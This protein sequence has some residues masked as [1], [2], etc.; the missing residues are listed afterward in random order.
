MS[1]EPRL[2]ADL[3]R[4][5]FEVAAQGDARTVLQIILVAQRCRAWIEPMLYRSV[6]VCQSSWSLPLFLRTIEARPAHYA[7][8]IKAIQIDPY[9][10][11]NDPAVTRIL[12]ICTRV[13]EL[14]DLSY[15]LTPF[16]VLA[17]LRL[18][19]MCMSLDVVDGLAEGAYFKHAA[20]AHLT[21]L[22]VLDPPQ[23]WPHI[24]FAHLPSLTHLALQN[25]KIEIRPANVPILQRILSTCPLLEV[26]VVCIPLCRPEDQNA[27]ATK[28]LVDD[29]RLV[30]LSQ[31]LHSSHNLWSRPFADTCAAVNCTEQETDSIDFGACERHLDNVLANKVGELGF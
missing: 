13:V 4:T 18:E 11:L 3:E 31:T 10:T 6:V 1:A 16:S 23:R 5:I 26:L 15:G 22:Q 27:Q 17:Q 8:W 28:L 12:S 19:R 30:I 14:V 9:I 2:P 24:P 29:L 21:H 7:K 20:F 25:Y